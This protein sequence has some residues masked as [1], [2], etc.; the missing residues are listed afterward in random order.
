MSDCCAEILTCLVA[1]GVD[2][3]ESVAPPA[4]SGQV[5]SGRPSSSFQTLSTMA[6]RGRRFPI[7]ASGQAGS[8]TSAIAA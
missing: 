5:T 2:V 6:G 4:V 1:A 7:T 8:D 3:I